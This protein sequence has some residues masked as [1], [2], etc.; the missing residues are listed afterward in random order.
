MSTRTATKRRAYGCRQDIPTSGCGRKVRRPLSSL[1]HNLETTDRCS[2]SEKR[3]KP[4][5]VTSQPTSK[6]ASAINKRAS[7]ND[8]LNLLEKYQGRRSGNKGKVQQQGRVVKGVP[9]ATILAT[10]K[11][12]ND[13]R[14]ALTT[15][16]SSFDEENTDPDD[17]A[18]RSLGEFD[19]GERM[20]LLKL[21]KRVQS[22]KIISLSS[23]QKPIC[24]TPISYAKWTVSKPNHTS[25]ENPSRYYVKG[26]MQKI[27]GHSAEDESV[28]KAMMNS[29][30]AGQRTGKKPCYLTEKQAKLNGIQND[31][32]API[33]C[34]VPLVGSTVEII[35]SKMD[36]T[37]TSEVTM[38]E[39]LFAPCSR[40]K[41]RD[42]EGSNFR[43]NNNYSTNLAPDKTLHNFSRKV[44]IGPSDGRGDSNHQEWDKVPLPSGWVMKTAS[45]TGRPY[46]VHAGYGSTWY[47]PLQPAPSNLKIAISEVPSA[48]KRS[49]E[50]SKCKINLASKDAVSDSGPQGARAGKEM[51]T[52]IGKKYWHHPECTL[53]N[54]G[55]VSGL[56]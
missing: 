14:H 23:Y 19:D 8:N 42:V 40:K 13:I 37:D 35:S 45:R 4:Q 5:Y 30:M 10:T 11:K 27:S 25:E 6:S 47:H 55:S 33:S 56:C 16:G 24:F 50:E 9:Q 18:S 48:L 49:S 12:S 44:P 22:N 32:V 21:Q 26:L 53:Q 28:F 3:C 46:Y 7:R 51:H 39:G 29:S 36:L 2:A 54:L 31:G 43:Q 15:K 38:N 41:S 1:N 17:L 34:A 52:K 20:R